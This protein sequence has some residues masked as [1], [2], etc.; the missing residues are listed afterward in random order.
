MLLYIVINIAQSITLPTANKHI[1][2]QIV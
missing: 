2:N 1:G